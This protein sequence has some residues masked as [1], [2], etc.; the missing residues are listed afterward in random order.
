MSAEEF[1]KAFTEYKDLLMDIDS[2]DKAEADKLLKRLD[3]DLK[4]Y[5]EGLE[6]ILGD[7]TE[8]GRT[9]TFTAEGDV[10][11][12]GYVEE[13]CEE[14][15]ILDFWEIIAFKPAK[16]KNVSITFG[17]Y[18]LSSKNLWFLPLES[19]EE[20]GK[21]GLRIALEGGREDDEDLL[22]AV[23]SLLEEMLGEYDAAT[24]LEY[25]EICS[26]GSN[27]KEEG[28]YPLTDLPE[29]VDWFIDETEKKADSKEADLK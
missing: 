2:L 27:P 26:L 14:A 21:L 29:Y 24:S 4:K 1:W 28:F 17:K 16:G 20:E 5:C 22:V 8:K 10:E 3:G 25:F 18:R 11:F 23:Y 19:E 6:F 7:L 9:L 15:P 12:F 13:L